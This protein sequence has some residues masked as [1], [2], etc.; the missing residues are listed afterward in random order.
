MPQGGGVKRSLLRWMAEGQIKTWHSYSVYILE[1]NLFFN[2]T[3][4]YSICQFSW[5]KYSFHEV[6]GYRIEK[7]CA[8]SAP[9]HHCPNLTSHSPSLGMDHRF[10]L[11]VNF[12]SRANHVWGP[13]WRSKDS[14]AMVHQV[15]LSIIFVKLCL[16]I[17]TALPLQH[18]LHRL[19]VKGMTPPGF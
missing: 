18:L 6:T 16:E 3:A 9:A 11:T 2:C 12:P 15:G 19:K 7:T 5:Y 10:V 4:I 17:N 13:S 8:P 1:K 14:N